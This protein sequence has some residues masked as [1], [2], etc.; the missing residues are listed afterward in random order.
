MNSRLAIVLTALMLVA[1]PIV[2]AVGPIGSV[3]AQPELDGM[4]GVPDAN[5]QEDLPV[6]SNSS[7]RATDLEGSVMASSHADSLQVVVTT[8]ER[9]SEYVNGSRVGGSG[10]VAL[11]FQDDT[12]HA[13]R[14][15]AVPADAVRETVGYLPEVVHG[16]H[17]SGDSWTSQVEARNGML[18]F[19]IPKFSSNS[20]TFSG[21]TTITGRAAVD[22]SSYAYDVGSI[23]SVSEYDINV[24]GNTSTESEVTSGTFADGQSLPIDV[25]GNS[26]PTD[27]TLTLTGRESTTSDSVS[28]NA[29]SNGESVGINVGGTTAPRNASVTLTGR[30]SST[31]NDQTG[32][33][34]GS[35]S[36][37]IAVDGNLDPVGPDGSGDPVVSVTGSGMSDDTTPWD[38]SNDDGHLTLEGDSGGG[39]TEARMPNPPEDEPIDA[40][41]LHFREEGVYSS[42]DLT[43]DI[44]INSNGL[45]KSASGTLVKS[46][47]TIDPTQVEQTAQ[48]VELDQPFDASGKSEITVDFQGSGSGSVK[49]KTDEDV[50][51]MSQ[52]GGSDGWYQHGQAAIEM[53]TIGDATVSADG[54]SK[55]FTN[56]KN[57]ETR[58]TTFDLS[59]S[60][61][62]DSSFTGGSS[63]SLD[64]DVEKTDRFGTEDPSVTIAGQTVSHTGLLAQGETVTESVDLSTGSDSISVSTG[65]TVDVS[66]EW[67]EVSATEDPSATI[68][69]Q[70]VSHTGI[71]GPGETVTESVDLSTGSDSISVS[72]GHT[73]DVEASWTERT[74][75]TN[76]KV[77]VNGHE[78]GGSTVG[79]LADGVTANLSTNTSWITDGTN[80]VTVRVGDGTL[81]GDAPPPMVD[82]D[83]RHDTAAEQTTEYAANGWV[84]RYNVSRTFPS[85]QQNATLTIP[86]SSE[87]YEIRYVQLQVNGGSWT[88]VPSEDWTLDGTT[89]NVALDDGDGDGQI[90]A[91]DTIAVRTSAYKIQTVEG[92]VTVVDPTAPG[93]PTVEA[94][95]RVDDRRP[96]FHVRVDGTRR[97]GRVHYAHGESWDDDRDHVIVDATGE[98]ELFLPNAEIGD[99]T[100]VTTI[101]LVPH[102]SSGDVQIRVARPDEP[103]ISVSPGNADV[104]ATVDYEFLEVQAG[105][106]YGLRSAS[107][108]RYV[109]KADA[110]AESVTLTDDDSEE[111]LVLEIP[112]ESGGGGG[113]SAGGAPSLWQDTGTQT[114]LQEVGV[115]VGWVALVL[116]LVAATGRSSLSG[117]RRW[118]LVGTVSVG[119]ALLSIEVLR[120]GM[121]SRSISSSLE[122]IIPL[123]G[124]AAIGLVIYSAYSWWQT[125]RSEASTPET[126]VTLDLGRGGD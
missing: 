26:D 44:Y 34:S 29:V 21:T 14:E 102:L 86:H 28:Q 69:G 5:V 97:G 37:S 51:T 101:P 2:G 118:L 74:E 116:L 30:E 91:G 98:Q 9:A 6:G 8:P 113:G 107:R 42:G 7:L 66:A 72:T 80:D 114:T 48:V 105:K 78:T 82:L 100:Q 41:V 108:S 25:A 94:E 125:R 85:D 62:I 46:D 33:L 70:T 90:D 18:F 89:L 47:Y 76:P 104:G 15:V 59:Q 56:L 53:R 24:T 77:V 31:R 126:K 99:T 11:V 67:T 38:G 35:D 10:G 17:E 58:S 57:G 49:L 117:R 84:E 81:S 110:G 122:Q 54:Q 83:Y 3:A 20:V 73:V 61:T 55:T 112:D 36:D 27:D 19:E 103:T 23:D 68:A 64:Y 1:A 124:L 60:P 32:T 75:T 43:L 119:S 45:D 63:P 123:A 39:T 92:K 4:V 88:D 109:D 40:L 115:V 71:L 120:P 50:G 79:T 96:G 111:T 52:F 12:N 95:I 106:T 93:D 65:H 87:V 22:Q 13:G 121:V 16:V